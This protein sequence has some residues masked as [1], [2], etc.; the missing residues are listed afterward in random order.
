MKINLT[1]RHFDTSAALTEAVEKHVEAFGQYHDNII[2]TDVVM[3]K[4]DHG[5]TVEFIVHVGGGTAVSKE[6]ESDLYKA[7]HLASDHVIRQLQKMK[8]K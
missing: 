2:S 4:S 1:A 6:T 8:G 7:M 5:D 3:E